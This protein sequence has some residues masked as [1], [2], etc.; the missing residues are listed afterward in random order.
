M[1]LPFPQHVH[2]TFSKLDE[3]L[4]VGPHL[5]PAARHEAVCDRCHPDGYSRRYTLQGARFKCR[6]C[7]DY[8]LCVKCYNLWIKKGNAVHDKSK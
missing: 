3:T 7:A 4:P 1:A 6:D 8:D 2:T 5:R